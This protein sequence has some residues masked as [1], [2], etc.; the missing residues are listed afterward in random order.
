M[1]KQPSEFTMSCPTLLLLLLGLVPTCMG[2]TLRLRHDWDQERRD[3]PLIM[4]PPIPTHENPPEILP[5]LPDPPLHMNPSDIHYTFA[6]PD[7]MDPSGPEETMGKGRP[8]QVP[9]MIHM[10]GPAQPVARPKCRPLE[11]HQLD[12]IHNQY[13]CTKLTTQGH[14]MSGEW[15]VLDRNSKSDVLQ[16][17]CRP[18]PCVEGYAFVPTNETCEPIGSQE[19]CPSGQELLINPYGEAECDCFGHL[20]PVYDKDSKAFKCYPEFSPLPCPPGEQLISG[21]VDDGQGGTAIKSRCRRTDCGRGRILTKLGCVNPVPCHSMD[22]MVQPIRHVMCEEAL[23]WNP[24]CPGGQPR[25]INGLCDEP[26]MGAFES[27]SMPPKPNLAQLRPKFKL[28]TKGM[29]LSN[30]AIYQMDSNSPDDGILPSRGAFSH[31]LRSSSSDAS[32][33][34]L[35][36]AAD[37]TES[38]FFSGLALGSFSTDLAAA[39]WPELAPSM[40]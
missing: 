22:P 14:C 10:T 26:S 33:M 7:E 40:A 16:G 29:S 32:S 24:F 31:F 34:S 8:L 4:D 1:L 21:P 25:N 19:L 6:V 35:K 36:A 9:E 13:G 3:T 17:V 28:A 38:A 11:V 30:F 15:L 39:A 20:L 2:S 18:R 27:V 12:P 5:R 37:S 23:E